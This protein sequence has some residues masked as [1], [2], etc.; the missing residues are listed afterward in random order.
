MVIGTLEQR[1][2]REGMDTDFSQR[3]AQKKQITKNAVEKKT[4]D[5]MPLVSEAVYWVAG[6]DVAQ[7][8]EGK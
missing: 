5:K 4:N 1:I 7:E 2:E 3:V 8:M 6:L